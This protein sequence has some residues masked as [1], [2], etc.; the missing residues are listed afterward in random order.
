MPVESPADA[1]LLIDA[2]E[3]ARQLAVGQTTIKKLIRTGRLPLK[4]FRLCRK[5]L[6]SRVELTEWIAAGMPPASCTRSRES[7]NSIDVERIKAT[8]SPR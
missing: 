4:R 6:F 5:R 7:K 3:L 8:R 1:P 2:R